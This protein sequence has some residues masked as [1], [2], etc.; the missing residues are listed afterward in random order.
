MERKIWTFFFFLFFFLILLESAF[1]NVE[2]LNNMGGLKSLEVLAA[3]KFDILKQEAEEA[4]S[5]AQIR[6]DLEKNLGGQ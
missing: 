2:T 6:K 3:G 4:M 5:F 1:I